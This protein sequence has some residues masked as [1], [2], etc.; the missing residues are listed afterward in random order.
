MIDRN[1]TLHSSEHSSLCYCS[2]RYCFLFLYVACVLEVMKT[3]YVQ[4]GNSESGLLEMK[5]GM[6]QGSRLGPLFLSIF[7]YDL[8]NC[9]TKF[10]FLVYA[11][12]TTIYFKFTI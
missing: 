1:R 11:D 2:F 10:Q 4:Y 3:E 6:S 9:G 12:N 5:T 8:V 7:I